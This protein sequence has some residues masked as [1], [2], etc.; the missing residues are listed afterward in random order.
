MRI[1]KVLV[2]VDFSPPSRVAVNYG[3]ALARKFRAKLAL[4]NV[5]QVP[6]VTVYTFP[7][8]TVWIEKEQREQAARMLSALVAPED[9]DDLDLRVL[10]ETGAIED[11]ISRAIAKEKADLVVMG[12]HGR[13]LFGRWI[14]G[15]VTQHL[16]RHVSVPVLTVNRVA[17]PLTL[18]RILFAT[19]LSEASGQALRT[20]IEIAQAAKSALTL[21]HVLDTRSHAYEGMGTVGIDMAQLLEQARAHL[22]TMAAEA[23][24]RNVKVETVVA[25]GAPA[26]GIF[27]VA[28][29]AG[30]DVIVITVEKKG[31]I[32]RTLLGSSAERVIRE[33]HLPV[34]SI[35]AGVRA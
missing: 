8:E 2:P 32:E 1:E 22:K 33:S 17:K 21:V 20:V 13:G 35:P 10:V 19:D 18:E 29:Q 3:V 31:L 4:L 9:Q 27:K 12:A 28:D 6:A 15:S 16:L 5:V 23:E 24:R 14:I 34:L 30:A 7:V 11:E 25:E 26:E